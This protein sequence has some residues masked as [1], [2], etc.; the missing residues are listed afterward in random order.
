ML[1]KF[2]I[3][4]VYRIAAFVGN[5]VQETAWWDRMEERGGRNLRYAP[6]YGRGFLQLT[7]SDGQF[8]PN[9]NYAKYFAFRGRS[10][11]HVPANQLTVWQDAVASNDYDAPNS[12][13]AYWSWNRG[14]AEADNV[15]PNT[16]RGIALAA[17]S[18]MRPRGS[19]GIYE[20]VAFRRVACLIN[21]P[22]SINSNNPQLN[23][24][25]DRYSGFANAQMVLYDLTA[26]PNAR[27]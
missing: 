18:P 23:G 14:N 13:G 1:R 5:S 12:A 26:F 2:S 21:L 15:S 22:A 8:T 25:V 24:L 11:T 17:N 4:S 27:G 3:T 16:R 7:N 9:S 20:N 19:I 6:W 10:V